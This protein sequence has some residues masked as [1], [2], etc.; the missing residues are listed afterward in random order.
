MGSIFP[1]DISFGERKILEREKR[2]VPQVV[3]ETKQ[4]ESHTPEDRCRGKRGE[5]QADLKVNSR[6][7]SPASASPWIIDFDPSEPA[8]LHWDVTVFT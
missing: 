3:K 5:N 2:K 1:K 6:N 7:L 4:K 8:A